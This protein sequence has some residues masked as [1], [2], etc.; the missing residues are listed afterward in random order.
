[1]S[2]RRGKRSKRI[3]AATRTAV[4]RLNPIGPLGMPSKLKSATVAE[5]EGMSPECN[6]ALSTANFYPSVDFLKK[7]CANF[8][9]ETVIL[10]LRSRFGSW[11][12]QHK[13][14][15]NLYDYEG[16]VYLW[17]CP[18]YVLQAMLTY[19]NN[20]GFAGMTLAEYLSGIFN[21]NSG[22]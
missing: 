12:E 18:K 17:A 14:G 21:E 1:M 13:L 22:H 6:L 5:I 10:D 16:G 11:L 19:H 3:H 9:G 15:Q 7:F 2:T 4:M 20:G 8:I